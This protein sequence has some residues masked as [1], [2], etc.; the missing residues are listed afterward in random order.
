MGVHQR[1][2]LIL[3]RI[4]QSRSRSQKVTPAP[5]PQRRRS[6]R[7]SAS[8]GSRS[9]Q[10]LLVQS[11]AGSSRT[12]IEP[13][14]WLAFAAIGLISLTLIV[15]IWT[16]TSRTIDEQVLEIRARTDQQVKSVAFVLAR[17][18]EDELQLVDQSLKIIQDDWTKNAGS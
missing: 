1:G 3:M 5:L 17:E 15:L 16:L 14:Q 18:V 12:K 8:G 9:M 13:A 6:K 4:K 10:P 2:R 7:R 11:R